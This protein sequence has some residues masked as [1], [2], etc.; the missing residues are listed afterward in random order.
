MTKS[1]ECSYGYAIDS[2]GKCAYGSTVCQNKYG[3]NSSYDSLSKNCECISG[4]RFN[5]KGAECISSD[6]AC[7]EQFGN[8]SKANILGDQC[9]CE[10]GYKWEGNICVWDSV[11][12]INTNSYLPPN[13][14]SVNTG[15]DDDFESRGVP[16][17]VTSNPAISPTTNILGTTDLSEGQFLAIP[18]FIVG[19]FY[20][21]KWLSKKA[22]SSS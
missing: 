20:F 2:R 16:S 18:A 13:N 11:D 19:L 8:N 9:E 7:K 6:D 5:L 17:D 14:S 3:Y 15:L 22:E 4:Y 1:C 21:L 10:Y 12:S